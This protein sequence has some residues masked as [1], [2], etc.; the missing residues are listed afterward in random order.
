MGS[1]RRGLFG[2][3]RSV[4]PDIDDTPRRSTSSITRSSTR[5][6]GHGSFFH[7]GNGEDQSITAAR[8]RVIDAEG[9]E[10]DADKALIAARTAVKEAR[11]QVKALEM[12]AKEEAR[13]AKLKAKAA[14]D[15]SRRAKPLGRHDR[16]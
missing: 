16:F 14:G 6:T 8:Q 1:E 15:I 4:S 5:S 10:R 11:D 7:R 13:L 9:A 12:E 2:R 3:R